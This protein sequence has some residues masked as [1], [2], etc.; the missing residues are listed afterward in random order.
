MIGRVIITGS[1]GMLGTALLK[2]L[3]S[4]NEIKIIAI[5]SQEEKLSKIYK[6]AEN[7]LIFNSL[8]KVDDK[9]PS[10]CVHCAF[11]RTQ[12]GE[13]L[14]NSLIATEE[15]INKLKQKKCEYLVNISSQSVY[16]QNGD[17]IQDEEDNVAPSSLYGM[18][19]LAIEQIVRLICTNNNMSFVNIRLGSLASADFDQ[20]MINRFYEKIINGKDINVNS[21]LP[22]VSYL[23]IDDATSA[24]SK[25]VDS[26][27]KGKGLANLYNLANNDWSLISDLANSCLIKA[28]EL[29]LGTACIVE[30]DKESNYNNVINSDKFYNDFSWEPKY[31]MSCLVDDIF[32]KKYEISKCN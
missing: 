22:K 5:S 25:L 21:G 31:S 16:P 28:K 11:P 8:D 20:R 24:L 19:K 7:V 3:K 9:I 32:N 10:I 2:K 12:N 23:H 6:D 1:G 4:Y 15:L 18:T 30:T 14:A 26:I 13:N 17:Y 29:N 27:I